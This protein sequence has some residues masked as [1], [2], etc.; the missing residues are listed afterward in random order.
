MFAI[1]PEYQNKG[2]VSGIFK[3]I[4]DKNEGKRIYLKTYKENPARHLYERFGFNKYEET[5]THRLME[6]IK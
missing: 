4:I 3:E 5:S 1:M 2:I 6:K